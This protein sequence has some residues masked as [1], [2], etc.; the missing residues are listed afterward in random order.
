MN[1]AV[2]AEM[3]GDPKGFAVAAQGTGKPFWLPSGAGGRWVKAHIVAE[4]SPR[5]A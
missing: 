5:A 2:Q 1:A 3:G 4:A